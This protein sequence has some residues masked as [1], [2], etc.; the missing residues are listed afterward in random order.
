M[1]WNTL[2]GWN[3]ISLDVL[4]V[5]AVWVDNFVHLLFL[6]SLIIWNLTSFAYPHLH[7][8][9][10]VYVETL[11]TSAV[12]QSLWASELCVWSKNGWQSW[13]SWRQSLSTHLA[14]SVERIK[15]WEAMYLLTAPSG[16]QSTFTFKSWFFSRQCFYWKKK[17]LCVSSC[18]VSQI[19]SLKISHIYPHNVSEWLH[20]AISVGR[21]WDPCL[22][23][24]I[25]FIWEMYGFIT[26]KEEQQL[27]S[28][29]SVIFFHPM[30]AVLENLKCS[31]WKTS[32][33]STL[34]Y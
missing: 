28:S 13:A 9:Q 23:I 10:L 11:L 22:E 21:Q 32:T 15:H 1:R 18:V 25:C 27:N 17:W 33:V 24:N 19:P 5:L 8:L 26:T 31:Y 30:T 34:N 12:C 20:L 14:L 3:S 4:L 2:S 7:S 16:F 6:L 29:V